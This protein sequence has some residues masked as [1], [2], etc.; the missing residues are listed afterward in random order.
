MR[1]KKDIRI[2]FALWP[3]ADLRKRLSRTARMMPVA[4]PGRR[5]P[6]HNLHLTLHFVGNVFFDELDCLQQAARQLVA[7]RFELAV[8]CHGHFPKPRVA[9]LGCSEVPEVLQT[10]HR[11]LGEYLQPCGYRPE[12]RRYSPHVTIAR[13]IK[14]EPTMQSFEPLRWKVDNFVLIESRA[15]DGGVKYEVIEA[16]ALK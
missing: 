7:P 8:D 14:T 13:K 1:D 6:D 2:F 16:Y 5:V 4:S 12:K 3:D 11:Q 15:V 9:W 10:L